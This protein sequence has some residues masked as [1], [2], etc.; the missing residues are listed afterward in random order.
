MGLDWL[1]GPIVTPEFEDEFDRLIRSIKARWTWNRMGKR[2]RMRQIST[3]AF[4]TLKTPRVAFDPAADQWA[5]KRFDPSKGFSEAKYWKG[6]NGFYVLDLVPACDGLPTYTNGEP[7]GYVEA[8]SF[9]AKFLHDCVDIIGERLLDA[10]YESKTVDKVVTYGDDLGS[11]AEQYAARHNIGA[12]TRESDCDGPEFQLD[13]VRS[14]SRWCTF[15]SSHNPKGEKTLRGYSRPVNLSRFD[16]LNWMTC[17][18]EIWDVPTY[19]CTVR[20]S[21]VLPAPAS[22]YWMDQRLYEAGRVGIKE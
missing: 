19:L 1:P 21:P 3:S 9:R 12:L 6:M 16:G 17:S 2:E 20:H 11:C 14:A 18:E 4:Q 8:Y 13:V 15:W 10:A 7:G 5:R 22:R